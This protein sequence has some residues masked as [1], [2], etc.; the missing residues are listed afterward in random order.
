MSA[1]FV[2]WKADTF[3]PGDD[4]A[5]FAPQTWWDRFFALLVEGQTPANA[6]A[7]ASVEL[8][9]NISWQ[10]FRIAMRAHPELDNRVRLAQ[11]N[12]LMAARRKVGKAVD[13]D[14]RAAQWFLDRTDPEFLPKQ[15]FSGLSKM[16][17]DE[18]QQ[19][20]GVKPDPETSG[21]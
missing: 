10:A 8:K 19:L 5:I 12:R 7:W 2:W 13:E 15:D 9:Q 4:P 6:C 16:T 3:R 20:A 18:L 1:G 17:D 21:P 11:S 14:V